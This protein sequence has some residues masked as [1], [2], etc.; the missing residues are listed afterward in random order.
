MQEILLTV[1]CDFEAWKSTNYLKLLNKKFQQQKKESC[2]IHWAKFL[3]FFL[4]IFF[5]SYLFS[6][7]SMAS[8]L[9]FQYKNLRA[10]GLF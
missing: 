6:S 9:M 3:H 4:L 7:S 1:L 5:S 10:K 2:K 8:I